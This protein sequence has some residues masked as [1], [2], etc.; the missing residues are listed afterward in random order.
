MQRSVAEDFLRIWYD[1]SEKIFR[2]RREFAPHEFLV[3]VKSGGSYGSPEATYRFVEERS[4]YNLGDISLDTL[5]KMMCNEELVYERDC[6]FHTDTMKMKTGGCD[7][8]SWIIKD[9]EYMHNERCPL[10]RK[11]K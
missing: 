11:I 1:G 9:S 6:G 7:C 8:G 5:I 3:F 10:H 2:Y 4:T